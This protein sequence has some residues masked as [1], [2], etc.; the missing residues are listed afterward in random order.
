MQLP[1]LKI[2]LLGGC[3]LCGF[4]PPSV[5]AQWGGAPLWLI[6]IPAA[7]LLLADPRGTATRLLAVLR[8]TSAVLGLARSPVGFTRGPRRSQAM[9]RH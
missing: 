9:L 4:V 6:G 2:W 7:S 3:A 8:M 5:L 1:I